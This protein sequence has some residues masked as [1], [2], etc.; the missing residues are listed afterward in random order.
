MSGLTN[1]GRVDGSAGVFSF[2]VSW[3]STFFINVAFFIGTLTT[4][5]FSRWVLARIYL[6]LALLF[7]K[8]LRHPF[9]HSF[10]LYT[11]LNSWSSYDLFTL[12]RLD[13]I[14]IVLQSSWLVCFIF[15]GRLTSDGGHGHGW[16]SKSPLQ[17]KARRKVKDKKSFNCKAKFNGQHFKG[18]GWWAFPSIG[19]NGIH[20]GC[21]V[22]LSLFSGNVVQ[23]LDCQRTYW[24]RIQFRCEPQRR[25]VNYLK[26]ATRKLASFVP[27]RCSWLQSGGPL[28][29][30]NSPQ[31]PKNAHV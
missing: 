28:I 17:T 25:P 19:S 20:F 22:T 26:Q 6:G 27:F 31:L 3:H 30:L 23:R 24:P 12:L 7:H 16:S 4:A 2:N 18:R 11:S 21:S 13:Y 1:G 9:R 29:S 5:L 15:I 14:K 8:N 10:L